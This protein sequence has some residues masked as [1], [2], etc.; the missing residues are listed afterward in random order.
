MGLS[1]PGILF[2]ILTRWKKTGC[3]Q[4]GQDCGNFMAL[5]THNFN[6]LA[7]DEAVIGTRRAPWI[8]K[9][10]GDT[11]VMEYPEIE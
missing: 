11:P 3:P 5:T 4:D 6:L 1:G 7:E 8:E 10:S 2:L 9:E